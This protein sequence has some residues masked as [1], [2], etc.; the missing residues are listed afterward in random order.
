LEFARG[1]FAVCSQEH[2]WYEHFQVLMKHSVINAGMLIATW[3]RYR[4][5]KDLFST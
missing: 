2:N 1:S 3:H 4:L 5:P